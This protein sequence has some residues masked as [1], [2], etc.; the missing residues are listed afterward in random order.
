MA[1]LTNLSCSCK[2]FTSKSHCIQSENL[3]SRRDANGLLI[4]NH[5]ETSERKQNKSNL[6][7]APNQQQHNRKY[8]DNIERASL[9]VNQTN[10]TGNNP[11]EIVGFMPKR[12]DFEVEYDND[13]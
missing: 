12:G 4:Q 6:N 1:L 2:L 8:R 11:A 9:T 13:A 5:R 3:L 10:K 7:I